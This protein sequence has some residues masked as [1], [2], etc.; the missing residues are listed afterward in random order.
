MPTR[1]YSPDMKLASRIGHR[2]NSPE[3]GSSGGAAK[4]VYFQPAAA[5]P[6]QASPSPNTKTE[7]GM[8]TRADRAMRSALL[9]SAPRLQR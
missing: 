3:T 2:A 7:M 9:S 4:S 5:I 8:A 6:K 1:T